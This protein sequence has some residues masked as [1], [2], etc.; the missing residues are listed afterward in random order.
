M[1]ANDWTL[2]NRGQ[3]IVGMVRSYNIQSNS[4]TLKTLY[5]GYTTSKSHSSGGQGWKYGMICVT[6]PRTLV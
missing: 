2:G 1:P 3:F 6:M 4:L 5:I